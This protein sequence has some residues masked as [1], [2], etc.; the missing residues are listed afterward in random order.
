MQKLI[1]TVVLRKDGERKFVL[2]NYTP[3]NEAVLDCCGF[4]LEVPTMWI[5]FFRRRHR[6]VA[7][8]HAA[9]PGNCQKVFV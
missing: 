4:F 7:G 1:L 9:G 6:T 8:S 5:R 2:S 3:M